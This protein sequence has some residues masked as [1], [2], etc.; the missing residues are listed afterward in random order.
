MIDF[1]LSRKTGSTSSSDLSC[2]GPL[3]WTSGGLPDRKSEEGFCGLDV[4]KMSKFQFLQL[5]EGILNHLN[6]RCSNVLWSGQSLSSYVPSVDF[7]SSTQKH[8]L[9]A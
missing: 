8:F 7:L 5:H 6:Q 2:R 4:I 9:F 1:K 3:S